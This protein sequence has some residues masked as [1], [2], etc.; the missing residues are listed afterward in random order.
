MIRKIAKSES[1]CVKSCNNFVTNCDYWV[2]VNRAIST[3][4]VDAGSKLASTCK[5]IYEN[6]R[7]ATL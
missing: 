7:M 1:D 4:I 6:W 2:G 3:P 5:Y